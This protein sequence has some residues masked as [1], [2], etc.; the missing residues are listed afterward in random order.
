MLL[1]RRG[2][3]RSPPKLDLIGRIF[4][5]AYDG[6][7]RSLAVVFYFLN[8]SFVAFLLIEEGASRRILGV[9]FSFSFYFLEHAFLLNN[10]SNESLIQRVNEPCIFSRVS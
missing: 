7:D 8:V 9:I 3:L 2:I 6:I 4:A 5:S 1:L 10:P